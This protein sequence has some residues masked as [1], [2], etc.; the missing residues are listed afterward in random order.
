MLMLECERMNILEE[1]KTKEIFNK[2]KQNERSD[3]EMARKML[4]V[5]VVWAN[6]HEQ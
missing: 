6:K 5:F 2:M 1:K 4:A 3:Q